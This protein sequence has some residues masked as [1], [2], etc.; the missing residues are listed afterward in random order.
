M[1]KTQMPLIIM[2][3]SRSMCDAT[4]HA[5]NCIIIMENFILF[6]SRTD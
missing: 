3:T 6:L 2:S 4:V 1:D 5:H